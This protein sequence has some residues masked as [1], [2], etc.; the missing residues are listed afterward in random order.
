MIVELL[1]H[2]PIFTVRAGFV[3]CLSVAVQV[4]Q[5]NDCAYAQVGCKSILHL[6]AC[7]V[8]FEIPKMM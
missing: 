6:Q 1:E 3:L 2:N 8:E 4:E 5:M 7:M